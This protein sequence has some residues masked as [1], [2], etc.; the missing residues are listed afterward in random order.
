[1]KIK[2]NSVKWSLYEWDEEIKF[3]CDCPVKTVDVKEA[4]KTF[5]KPVILYDEII[6]IDDGEGRMWVPDEYSVGFPLGGE[7][8]EN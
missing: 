3:W 7:S 6:G 8:Y 4:L 5:G 1:M 2:V